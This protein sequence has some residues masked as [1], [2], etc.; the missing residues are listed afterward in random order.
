MNWLNFPTSAI[1]RAEMAS[2]E[3]VEIGVWFRLSCYCALQ[4]N[5]GVIK[6]AR[7]W[8]D[9]QWLVT[10]GVTLADVDMPTGL[11]S[12]NSHGSLT[13]AL[14]PVAKEREVAAKRAAGNATAKMR[15][16]RGVRKAPPESKYETKPI[17]ANGTEQPHAEDTDEASKATRHAHARGVA[18]AH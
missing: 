1:Q 15:W 13:V 18:G 12:W 5:G 2:A 10:A 9:R 17:R 4:E 14:Y 3:P 8:V 7:K 16:S 11:W 6:N